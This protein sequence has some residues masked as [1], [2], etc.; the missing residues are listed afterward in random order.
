MSLRACYECHA[1]QSNQT[2]TTSSI[3]YRAHF[4][5]A[6]LGTS[7]SIDVNIV[8]LVL[9][10]CLRSLLVRTNTADLDSYFV[11]VCKGRIQGTQAVLC[12]QVYDIEMVSCSI[13][14]HS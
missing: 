1:L 8:C 13:I 10:I 11:Q 7:V 9:K 5:Q 6:W 4:G 2:F 12:D 3:L 14:Q